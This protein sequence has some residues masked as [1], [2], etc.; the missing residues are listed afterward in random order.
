MPAGV[1]HAGGGDPQVFDGQ[2]AGAA[3]ARDLPGAADLV[4]GGAQRFNE[5]VD[6]QY[7]R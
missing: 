6:D 5:E 1:V 2:L 3:A 4:R 7:E